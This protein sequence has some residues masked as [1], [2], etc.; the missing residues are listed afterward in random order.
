[1]NDNQKEWEF[2][3][4]MSIVEGRLIGDP[5][6]LVDAAGIEVGW[7]NIKTINR[8]PDETGEWVDKEVFVPVGVENP[9]KVDALKKFVKDGRMLQVF[10]SV[11]T[12]TFGGQPFTGVLAKQVN[13][14]KKPY[15]PKEENIPSLPSS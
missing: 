11:N 3:T 7:L 1:M 9:G 13:F 15:V 6:F 14:G 8:A 5:Q 4:N 12:W 10:G 2:T